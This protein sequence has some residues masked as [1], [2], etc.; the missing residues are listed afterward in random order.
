MQVTE[1]WRWIKGRGWNALLVYAI[2]QLK[3]VPEGNAAEESLPTCLP[4]SELFQSRWFM[5][6]CLHFDSGRDALLPI[7]IA[8]LLDTIKL[9]RSVDFREWTLFKLTRHQNALSLLSFTWMEW[10]SLFCGVFG[11]I[12]IHWM[13]VRKAE[14]MNEIFSAIFSTAFEPFGENLLINVEL[15]RAAIFFLWSELGKCLRE[16]KHNK[17]KLVFWR[18]LRLHEFLS[19]FKRRSKQNSQLRRIVDVVH[20]SWR[21]AVVVVLVT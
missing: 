1:S 14:R 20:S 19:F 9:L 12:S 8:Q 11:E 5:C 10:N 17:R 2:T 15:L 21:Q 13:C 4:T 18:D 6:L 16:R 3:F 7:S